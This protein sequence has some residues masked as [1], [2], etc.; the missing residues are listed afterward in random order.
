MPKLIPR[1]VGIFPEYIGWPLAGIPIPEYVNVS[2]EGRHREGSYL[3]RGH[4]VRGSGMRLAQGPALAHHWQC[5][6]VV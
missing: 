2:V 4:G 5:A 1:H 3:D 6:E